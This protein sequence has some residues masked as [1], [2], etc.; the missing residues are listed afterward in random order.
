VGDGASFFLPTVSCGLKD[1][2]TNTSG[3]LP[4]LSNPAGNSVLIDGAVAA[5]ATVANFQ[6]TG[7]DVG[8]AATGNLTGL[9]R[10]GASPYPSVSTALYQSGAS[11]VSNVTIASDGTKAGQSGVEITNATGA[12][13][14][15]DTTISNMSRNGLLVDGG[16]PTVQYQGSI[17]NTIAGNGPVVEIR[18]TI[19]AKVDI[20]G[21]SAPAGSKVPNQV[22]DTGGEGI[23]ISD[24]AAATT[25]AID[26]VSLTN[27][28]N[29]AIGVINDSST[30]S[31]SSGAGSGISKTTPGAAITVEGAAPVFSYL[32]PI[33]NNPA[34]ASPASFLVNVSQLSGGDVLI[35][36]L[37]GSPFRDTGDGIQ[38]V[39]NAN[40]QISIGPSHI[41]S[42]GAQGVL[43]NNNS[44]TI[45]L[46]G[47]KV[48]GASTAGVLATNSPLSSLEL[49]NLNISLASPGAIGFQAS[50]FGAISSTFTNS[51]T[52]ASTTQPAV[53][54][55]DS[56]PLSMTFN[57]IS[58]GVTAGTND[59]M[60]FLGTTG[61][62]FSVT[63]AFLVNGTK[64][65][66]AADVNNAAGVTLTLPP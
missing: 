40:A 25:I 47:I 27:N 18:D 17:S 50:D 20:A 12:I 8:I 30:T 33:T 14:F 10:T 15:N 54:I 66:E 41:T 38:I 21:G 51:I 13:A 60:E 64:G 28:V 43:I 39:D 37:P 7:S 11:I 2:A 16:S 57:T 65:T 24:N 45:T 5:G 55:N 34:A 53:Q 35:E 52:T 61:G 22:V 59:A 19:A 56:G 44:S 31:I 49:R 58:S 46:T 62:T 48:D 4:L 9:P 6:I 23:R 26:N 1:I 29:A 63:S 36:P 42:R 3:Q 32:G